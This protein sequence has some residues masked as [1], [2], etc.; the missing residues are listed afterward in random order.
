MSA[1]HAI[2]PLA[3]VMLAATILLRPGY[4]APAGQAAPAKK[5]REPIHFVDVS[6]AAGVDRLRQEGGHPD[7]DY[8]IESL[9]TGGAWLDYDGDGDPDLYLAQGVRADDRYKGPPDQLL[10]ND[11]DPDGD[12]IPVFTDV[13]SAAGLGDRRHSFGVA[14]ADFDNDADPDIYL[15][16][17]GPNRLYR[18]NGDGT[19]ADIAVKA[20]VADERW[21]ASAT[22]SDTDRDGDLDLYVANYVEFDYDRYPARG[23][24]PARGWTT[25]IWKGVAVY[26]GP[27][28]LEPAADSFF[29]NEGDRDGDGVTDFT[30]VS[31]AVGLAKKEQYFALSAHFFDSDGDGDD[32][33]YVANDSVMNTYFVNRG[34]GTFKEISVLT[35]LAYNEQGSEQAGMGISSGDYD[36][37]GLLDLVVTNF[38]HDHD[39]L[40]RNE[41]KQMFLDVSFP[42]GLGQP[43]FVTLS[44]GVGFLDLDQDGWQDIFISHGHVYPQVDG[45]GLGAGFRQRN[46][47]FRNLRDGTLE[48]VT[49][50]AGPGLAI[51]KSSR[52]ILPIDLDTDGDLDLLVTNLND[53]PDLLRNEGAAGG[54]LQVGL[55]GV[56]SNRDGIGARVSI[57]AGGRTQIREIRR[58]CSYAASTLPI[59]HFGLGALRTVDRLEVRWPSGRTSVEKDVAANQRITLKEPDAPADAP[60]TQP[61]P[62]PQADHPAAEGD[63]HSEGDQ[64]GGTDSRP[65]GRAEDGS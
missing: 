63:K 37:N 46:S 5:A 43:T 60:R 51:V 41:G 52:A 61:A 18:N 25:C 13:T 24:K 45:H 35:G 14:V 29:R 16:N 23:E 48:D 53:S 20:G 34:D 64:G 27:R 32:D 28:N 44:W 49:E 22:W 6:R 33:L 30:E 8:I 10:R 50:R 11:G 15:A 55:Q 57:E 56:T 65:P 58:D 7:V 19:F 39:T 47:V 9:G 36:G 40:Y 31:A 2:H 3:T 26:C 12:G 62:E 21:S 54:W 38:A 17:W 42:S 1:R 59:A 4:A